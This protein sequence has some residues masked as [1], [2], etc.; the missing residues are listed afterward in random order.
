LTKAA[1]YIAR[2]FTRPQSV[3]H[4]STNPARRRLT[5]LIGHNALPLRHATNLDKVPNRRKAKQ[6]SERGALTNG[7]A[8]RTTTR[9]QSCCLAI[10]CTCVQPAQ[11]LHARTTE[12]LS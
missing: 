9:R 8:T 4:P 11:L 12:L 1:G 3:A 6:G 2:W 10:S 5:S 7:S